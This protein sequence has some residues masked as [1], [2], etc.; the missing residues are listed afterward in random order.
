M[1]EEALS[2][3]STT[4]KIN[5]AIAVF[6]F[7]AAVAAAFSAGFVAKQIKQQ[8]DQF[9]AQAFL[10]VLAYER[11]VKFSQHM[12]VVRSVGAKPASKLRKDERESILVVVNFLNHIAHLIR[13]HYVVPKQILLLY[14]PS[15]TRC[16]ENLLGIDQWLAEQRRQTGDSRYYLHF[17]TLCRPKTVDLIW[18]DRSDEIIWTGDEYHPPL[19]PA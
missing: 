10:G 6:T 11:E 14:S 3:K 18:T 4:D 8:L 12:D 15:I 2:D 17:E 9:R 5:L 1:F 16:H 19:G 7:L 13:N